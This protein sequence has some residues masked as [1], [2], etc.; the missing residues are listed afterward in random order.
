MRKGKADPNA[1]AST[2]TQAH[3]HNT[4]ERRGVQT[5]TK[6]YKDAQRHT[7][8]HARKQYQQ[9][10]RHTN[11]HEHTTHERNIATHVMVAAREVCPVLKVGLLCNE[12]ELICTQSICKSNQVK[13]GAGQWAREKVERGGDGAT[14]RYGEPTQRCLAHEET[15]HRNA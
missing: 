5:N 9:T 6:T 8:T 15:H 2:S 1:Q 3:T 13:S 12:A 11:T 10:Q 14:S 4:H 7:K